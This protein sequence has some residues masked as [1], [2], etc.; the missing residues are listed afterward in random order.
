M[1]LYII[2]TH[3]GDKVATRNCGFQ[4]SGDDY[5]Q[6]GRRIAHQMKTH[7]KN[8]SGSRGRVVP[9]VFVQEG[10][11]RMDVVGRAAADVLGGFACGCD[12]DDENGL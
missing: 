4:L 11:Y 8:S 5:T 1:S 12:D 9:T 2:D 10:G 7:N 3:E 6:M